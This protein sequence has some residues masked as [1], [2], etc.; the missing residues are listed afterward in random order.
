MIKFIF[1]IKSVINEI[2]YTHGGHHVGPIG[3]VKYSDKLYTLYHY[4]NIH[5]ELTYNKH[6]YTKQRLSEKNKRF[7]WGNQY[8][9]ELTMEQVQVN[10]RNA[11]GG[12]HKIRD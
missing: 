5:P 9:T 6:Q 10:Y 2:N 4:I 1:S 11:R 12:V 3:N 7:G 8:N